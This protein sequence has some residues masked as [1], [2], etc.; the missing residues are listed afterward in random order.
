[1]KVALTHQIVRVVDRRVELRLEDV[2][3]TVTTSQL[4]TV[5]VAVVY[6]QLQIL[7]TH[8]QVMLIVDG[9]FIHET[10]IVDV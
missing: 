10:V 8:D 1:L 6:A 3:F 5:H 4:F 7:Y 2:I 9:A